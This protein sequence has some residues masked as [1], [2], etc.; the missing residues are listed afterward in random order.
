[1][2]NTT[3]NGA[4]ALLANIILNATDYAAL[5]RISTDILVEDLVEWSLVEDD[6]RAS[7]GIPSIFD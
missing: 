5:D 1:M 3:T 2:S 7:L 4:E 6:Y